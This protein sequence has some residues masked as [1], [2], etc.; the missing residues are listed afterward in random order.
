MNTIGR[1][2]EG[3]GIERRTGNYHSVVN[4]A[5]HPN[6]ARMFINLFLSRDG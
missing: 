4:Q 6:A 1:M 2:K 3:A 5:P